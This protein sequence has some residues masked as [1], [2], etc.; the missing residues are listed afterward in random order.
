MR[1]DNRAAKKQ[2]RAPRYAAIPRPLRRAGGRASG[3]QASSKSNPCVQPHPIRIPPIS[4][5]E[6][7]KLCSASLVELS[8]RHDFDGWMLLQKTPAF[9]FHGSSCCLGLLGDVGSSLERTLKSP[10]K[11]DQ[12][13]RGWR[14]QCSSNPIDMENNVNSLSLLDTHL[15]SSPISVCEDTK[16][17][18]ENT[19]NDSF[20][21]QGTIAW[22][23]MRREWLG[24]NSNKCRKIPSEPSIT[25]FSTYDD[26]L[27]TSRPFPQAIPLSEMVDFLVDIWHDEGLYD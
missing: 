7:W 27:S 2:R 10:F 11:R 8:F 1:L 25:W 16:V 23:E 12:P 19:K 4:P 3:I 15:P 13:S 17:A 26:L 14:G 5:K 22:N 6:I 18:V 21:N 24:D 9:S 20:V